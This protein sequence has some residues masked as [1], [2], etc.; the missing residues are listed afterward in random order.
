MQHSLYLAS[1]H[2]LS[3]RAVYKHFNEMLSSR[4]LLAW[5]CITQHACK[6]VR[7]A[8]SWPCLNLHRTRFDVSNII[9]CKPEQM[10]IS[11]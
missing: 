11:I 4:A 3:P 1:D 6:A 10:T 9:Q 7:P 5:W 2:I 8:P